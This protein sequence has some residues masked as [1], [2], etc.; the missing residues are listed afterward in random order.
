MTVLLGL[1]PGGTTGCALKIGRAYM[2]RT[3]VHVPELW[4]FIKEHRPDKVAFEVFVTAGRVD[5]AMIHTI[6]LVGSIRGICHVLKIP[7]YGQTAQ[8]R[9]GFIEPAKAILKGTPHT[10]HE[11]DALAHLLLLEW[12]MKEGKL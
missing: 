5:A 8:S 7:G 9:K 4:D 11:E 6:E 2:T 10:K 3:F 1:D 12:R